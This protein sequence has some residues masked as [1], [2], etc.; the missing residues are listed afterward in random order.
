MFFRTFWEGGYRSCAHFADVVALPTLKKMITDDP[1]ENGVSKEFYNRV[2]KEY[3][4][5]A[6]IKKID[7]GGG[8]IHGSAEDFV[9]DTS[10]RLLLSHTAAPLTNEQ[11][12]IGSN[13]SFAMRDILI[14]AQQDY[15]MSDAFAYLDRYY[16]NVNQEGIL[17]LMNC[18][19]ET[20]NNGSI[21]I[22]QGSRVDKLYLLIYGIVEIIDSKNRVETTMSPGSIIG[23]IEGINGQEVSVTY[24]A[25]TYLRVLIIPKDLYQWFI[26]QYE[27]RDE[28]KRVSEN[29]NLLRTTWLFGEALPSA[30]QT[31]VA[32][33]AG[34]VHWKKG[35]EIT[36]P[37]E[38]QLFLLVGGKGKLYSQKH[39]VI[40]TLEEG[41]FFCEDSVI[42][43]A[44]S[45]FS[46]IAETDVDAAVI[47]FDNFQNI[48]IVQWKLFEIFERRIKTFKTYF[49]IMWYDSYTVNLDELDNQ[50]KELF[51]ILGSIYTIYEE[52][53][54]GPEYKERLNQYFEAMESHLAYEESLMTRLEYPRYLIQKNG[55][56]SVLT[57]I[58]K[59]KDTKE[60]TDSTE[61][62]F[63]E[64]MKE[65]LLVHTLIEDRKYSRFFREKGLR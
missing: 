56:V 11:K 39:T 27:L 35:T 28:I 64:K 65:W 33:A 60:H 12:E 20:I 10:E 43:G 4:E 48:P 22:K 30:A 32:Q 36:H 44:P 34:M 21:L 13:A 3:L 40:D 19:V 49:H 38:R 2:K 25:A 8:M 37:S 52:K 51:D 7:I 54:F 26:D 61:L 5:P 17:M 46:F 1:N 57:L 47:P 62:D 58:S 16:P 31:N 50:H 18:P 59:Y 24:R 63:L 23:E 29:R 15:C 45:M 42:T 9:N 55:H 14:K 6:T 53:G 41:D